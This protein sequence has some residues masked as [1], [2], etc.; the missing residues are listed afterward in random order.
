MLKQYRLLILVFFVTFSRLIEF[1]VVVT[2]KKW[3]NVWLKS[4]EKGRIGRSPMI[5]IGVG[6]LLEASIPAF[7]ML[8]IL[9]A[10]FKDKYERIIG[11][12]NL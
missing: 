10:P 6:A 9:I 5:M 7:A 3:N 11:M 12:N 1:Q 8:Q 4:I 2:S